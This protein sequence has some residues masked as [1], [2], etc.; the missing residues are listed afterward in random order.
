MKRSFSIL[1]I[2]LVS[3]TVIISCNKSSKNGNKTS[4]AKAQESINAW[5]VS[6][7]NEYPNYKPVG[8]GELTPRYQKSNRTYQ[9]YNLIE[10]EKSKSTP[11]KKTIDSLEN[12]LNSN[13]GE[14]LGYTIMHKYQ[15]KSM[16]GETVENENLFFLDSLYRIITILN[17]DAYDQIMD[18]KLIFR[19]ELTDSLK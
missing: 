14:F 11:N 12:L 17:S 16:A 4:T 9:L 2:A 6:K 15:T 18:E 19:Q 10:E 13:K 3:A 8:F 1:I 5:M 7:I